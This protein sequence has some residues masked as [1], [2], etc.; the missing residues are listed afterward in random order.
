MR[1]IHRPLLLAVLNVVSHPWVALF[2]A[3]VILN[4][5]VLLACLKLNIS[6]DQNKLFDPNVKFFRDY[7]KFS[8]T[9]PENEAI[10]LVVE[11]ANPRAPQPPVRRWTDFADA[12]A[13][14]L[15]SMREYVA[16]VDAKVPTEQLGSQGILFDDPENVRRNF[17]DVKRFVPLAKLWAEKPNL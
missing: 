1:I 15:K 6:T 11:R 14:R 8:E 10:Y 17:E 4:A 3:A 7:L 13:V 16:S 12:L 2:C 9:F 5:C